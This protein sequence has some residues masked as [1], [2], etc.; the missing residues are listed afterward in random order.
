MCVLEAWKEISKE[1]IIQSFEG[2]ALIIDVN[3]NHDH[4]ISCFKPGKA[5]ADGLKM[6]EHEITAFC[7][8]QQDQ[9]PF[10]I[11]DSDVKDVNIEE[12]II[13]EDED[14]IDIEI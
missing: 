14:D 2:C 10:D 5:C 9:N 4:K 12:N 7:H 11:T 8:S 6:L 13:T 1:M 3:G